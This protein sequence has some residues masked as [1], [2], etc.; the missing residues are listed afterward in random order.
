MSNFEFEVFG[1]Y[2]VALLMSIGGICV[3][4][5]AVLSGAFNGADE[6]ALRFYQREIDDDR[7]A[8]H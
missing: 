2:V 5:W 6:E 4:I 1:P 7:H 3:F 8:T